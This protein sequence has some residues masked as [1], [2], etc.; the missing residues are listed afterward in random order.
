MTH[1][2]PLVFLLFAFSF[3]SPFSGTTILFAEESGIGYSLGCL[4]LEK[5]VDGDTIDVEYIGPVRLLC[6]DAEEKLTSDVQEVE[7]HLDF[8]EWIRRHENGADVGEKY[9]TPMGMEAF[10]FAKKSFAGV[11]R[12]RLEYD[13][14]SRTRGYYWRTLAYVFYERDGKEIHYNLELVREGYSPYYTKYGY[15]KR[16]HEEFL[17]AEREARNARRGIW[18]PEGMHYPDY[19]KR[20]LWWNQRANAIR[21]FEKKYSNRDNYFMLGSP[22]AL[23]GLGRSVGKEIVVFGA[24]CRTNVM[25]QGLSVWLSHTVGNDFQVTFPEGVG[26]DIDGGEFAYFRGIL[27]VSDDRP[28]LRVQEEEGVGQE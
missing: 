10:E 18:N 24:V 5:V 27:R 3:L 22:Y 11:S 1:A 16:Y 12:V 6:V 4:D 20:V 25:R 17:A 26:I 2:R 14:A 23:S 28:I 9:G 8:G 19:R 15:S 21:N 13:T 7:A